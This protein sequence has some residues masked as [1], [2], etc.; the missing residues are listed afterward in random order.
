MDEEVV[1][2]FNDRTGKASD[3]YDTEENGQSTP[4]Q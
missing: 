4:L 2:K 1:L 3:F